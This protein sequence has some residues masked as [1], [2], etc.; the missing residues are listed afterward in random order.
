MV[1]QIAEY[2]DHLT[3][4]RG[5][6]RN[7][8]LAYERD[9]SRYRS[10]CEARGLTTMTDIDEATVGHFLM[11]LRA[12]DSD[13]QPLA[14]ASA[15]RAVV[16]VRGLHKFAVWEGNV[17]D[18]AAQVVTPPRPAMRLPKALSVAQITEILAGVDTSTPAGLR[19]LALL[20]VMYGSGCRVSEVLGIDLGDL[21]VDRRSLLVTGKGNKQRLVPVGSHA[22]NAFAAYLVRARPGF[23]SKGTGSQ[24]AFLNNR[25]S[26]LTRQTAWTSIKAAGQKV[27]IAGLHPHTFRHSFATHLLEAGADI[28]V[29]QELLGHASVTTTQI[30]TLVTIEH[31]REVYAT[32]HPRGR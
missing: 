16:A 5:L 27:G 6:A 12:G 9:L 22:A 17:S 15:A 1:A 3:V 23:A 20:E 13:H 7:T 11:S 28:R 29:V 24:A 25:G 2:L 10:F 32:S 4:E 14:S 31:L 30:Y 26:R 18:N 8:L 21:D 19:D